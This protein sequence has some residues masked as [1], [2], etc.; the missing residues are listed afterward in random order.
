MVDGTAKSAQHVAVENNYTARLSVRPNVSSASRGSSARGT[1][2]LVTGM[3]RSGTTWV[4]RMLALGG[5]IAYFSEPLNSYAPGPLISVTP[6]RQFQYIALENEGRFLKP[7][8]S[9][10][11]LK[12]PW[13]NEVAAIRT[14][15]DLRRVLRRAR[16]FRRVSTGSSRALLKDPFAFFSIPWFSERLA[17][18]PVVVVRHPAAV[19]SSM[20]RLGWRFDFNH[21]LGQ[22][23]LMDGLLAPYRREIEMLSRSPADSVTHAAVLWRI[24]YGTLPRFT[25]DSHDILV[26]R[27]EA[28]SASPVEQFK[29]LSCSLGLRFDGETA[30]RIRGFTS[31]QNPT[32]LD[33]PHSVRV[34][35]R[36][37]LCN[38]QKR[39]MKE[40]IQ[41]VREATEEVAELYYP[42][43]ESDPS[44]LA[45][46][47]E[48]SP[49]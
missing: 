18:T 45:L 19:A 4:G 29:R 11:A 12:Y 47:A 49:S 36:A 9:L 13:M 33:E 7:F 26:V 23:L 31:D 10:I 5:G 41:L 42:G 15:R 48:R 38:W 3:Q 32:E 46:E 2:I 43:F 20:K 44:V 8:E 25:D 27:H 40:E 24:I 14:A 21:L 16:R 37:N 17:C 28:L 35:S 30:E 6:A 39:L 34:N 22:P 1:P